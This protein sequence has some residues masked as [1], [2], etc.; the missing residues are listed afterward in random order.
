MSCDLK[1]KG[2]AVVAANP[3]MVVT[4]FG[5]GPA[6]LKKMGA[7]PVDPTQGFKA[8]EIQLL[9]F[10]RPHMRA[11]HF[12]WSSFFVRAPRPDHSARH[13]WRQSLECAAVE[14]MR[15]LGRKLLA[16]SDSF[17]G[18]ALRRKRSTLLALSGA[19]RFWT[20]LALYRDPRPAGGRDNGR[21]TGLAWLRSLQMPAPFVA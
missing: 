9:S 15:S 17:A 16:L 12:A 11:F 13:C 10:Q 8:K 14:Q 1:E 19:R 3:A 4:H 20:S 5:P 7:M 21:T 6:G 2:I 18:A